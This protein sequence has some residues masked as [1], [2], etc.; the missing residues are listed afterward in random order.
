MTHASL[1]WSR[2][3]PR[4]QGLIAEIGSFLARQLGGAP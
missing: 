4:V 3:V 2:R 1:N